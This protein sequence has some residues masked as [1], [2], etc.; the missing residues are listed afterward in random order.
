[1]HR[2][3]ETEPPARKVIKNYSIIAVTL[4]SSWIIPTWKVFVF[5]LDTYTKIR[6]YID[7]HFILVS[8]MENLSWST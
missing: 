7:C 3:I 4:L 5:S 2:K 1:M 6:N 8:D